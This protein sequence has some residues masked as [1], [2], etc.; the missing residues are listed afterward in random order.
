MCLVGGGNKA[1]RSVPCFSDFYFGGML[2][3]RPTSL[4]KNRSLFEKVAKKV[5]EIIADI[6]AAISMLGNK[7]AEIR[8]L[9][10]DAESLE[11]IN[12]M[13]DSLLEKA[14]ESY[15]AENENGQKNNTQEGVKYSFGVT[16]KEIDEYVENA[17]I[18]NNDKDYKKYADISQ[19]LLQDVGNEI[20]IEG[21][22]HALRDNDI[23]HINNSHGEGNKTEKYPVTRD[24]IK[25]IPFIVENYD[26]VFVSQK[27]NNRIGLI[28]V[29]VSENGLIYYLEQVTTQYGNEKLLVNKQMIKTGINDIPDIRGLKDAINKK[30]GQDKFLTDLKEVH[31]VYAQSVRYPNPNNSIPEIK[32]SVKKNLG[33]QD[34]EYLTAVESGD[35][36]TA[37]RMVD[38]AAKAAG[39]DS[40]MLYHGTQSFGFTEFDLARMDD[41]R[42][43]FLTDNPKIA[44]TYSGVEGKR[45]VSKA[46]GKNIENMSLTKQFFFDTKLF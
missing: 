29:K 37:R 6:K 32:K 17:Y 36:E 24:D 34:S 40:P 14:G 5:K 38:E 28:Y 4:N 30:E 39:Y 25:S 20:S 45:E 13:F 27:D 8:A 1:R 23:R 19:R 26:K 44:S 16:Q 10:D 46:Y 41:K 9:K 42:C 7:D 15:R 35:T 33:T 3:S 11:K 22:S 43:I 31:Q 12:A 21:Y 18:K 2:A